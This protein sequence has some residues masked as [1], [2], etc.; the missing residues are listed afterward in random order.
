MVVNATLEVLLSEV[1]G[2]RLNI[3][4]KEERQIAHLIIAVKATAQFH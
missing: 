1:C 3:F 2:V 4:T